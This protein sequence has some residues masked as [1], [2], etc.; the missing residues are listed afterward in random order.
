MRLIL[1]CFGIQLVAVKVGISQ[2]FTIS[3]MC[4]GASTG[5][6]YLT[7]EDAQGNLQLDTAKLV[8]G[9]FNFKGK[10][11]VPTQA[12]LSW[13]LAGKSR[14]EATT[15]Y[16]EPVAMTAVI[17]V[18]N[19]R[20]EY[21]FSGSQ[22]QKD[23]EWLSKKRLALKS[24]SLFSQRLSSLEKQF[25]NSHPES[26]LSSSL[27]ALNL[28]NWS[29][30]TIMRMYT[31][32][33][34]IAQQEQ[35][36]RIVDKWL[37]SELENAVGRPA[38]YFEAIDIKGRKL[39]LSQFE[40][41][42]VLLDFWASWCVPC[43]QSFPVLKQ[44]YSNYHS[45]GLEVIC[46]SEDESLELW[47]KAVLSEDI[48]HLN[49]VLSGFEI[50]KIGTPA[51]SSRISARYGISSFPTKVLIDK[52]GLIIG[53]WSGESIENTEAIERKFAELFR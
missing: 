48:A 14:D 35:F 5:A 22:T 28:R 38:K 23:Y 51:D 12:E 13:K 37:K 32:L 4:R 19:G 10:I 42:Y 27:L 15:F 45:K 40:G 50:S 34:P 8:R 39:S 1:L 53:R 20:I 31:S 33:S 26:V 24:D 21:L 49:Q 29:F 52:G 36:G 3:G 6:V 41:K 25:V 47:Q 30:D 9:K 16:L 44:W 17:K 46:I 7:F 2:N 18:S 43:R 11:L